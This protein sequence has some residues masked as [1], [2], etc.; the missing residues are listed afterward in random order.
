[1]RFAYIVDIMTFSYTYINNLIKGNNGLVRVLI[2]LDKAITYVTVLLY[3]LLLGYTFFVVKDGYTLFYRSLIIPAVSFILVSGFRKFFNAPRPY[4]LYE[5]KP[6]LPKDTRGKSFPSR[7]VFSIFMVAMAWLQL[8]VALGLILLLLG[9]AL[10]IV[11]VLG[12]VH[13]IHD[14]IA[15]AAIALIVGGICFFVLGR[16]IGILTLSF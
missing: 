14:V 5:F 11:R 2:L 3:I 8:S 13:F 16:G 6:A 15:G 1:M 7:H 9:V 4:E 12:G 10:A